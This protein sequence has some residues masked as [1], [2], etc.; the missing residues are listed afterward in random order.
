MV[1]NLFE[2]AYLGVYQANIHADPTHKY[3]PF[4]VDQSNGNVKV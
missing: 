1:D 2:V 3:S 4:V